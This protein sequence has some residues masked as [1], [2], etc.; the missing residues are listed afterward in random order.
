MTK[1]N[2]I[3]FDNILHKG[4][5]IFN[6]VIEKIENRNE[7]ERKE[8]LAEIKP[9]DNNN[10]K[11]YEEINEKQRKILYQL[12]KGYKT[13]LSLK[14]RA[15][16]ILDLELNNITLIANKNKISRNKVKRWKER[17][18]KNQE[19]LHKIGL[20]EPHKLKRAIISLLSDKRRSG[21][22]PLFQSE[23]IA[24]I[25]LISLQ[26]PNIMGVPIS[27]WTGLTLKNKVI[28]LEI[29][30]NISERTIT[31]YLKNLDINLHQYKGWLNSMEKNP[32]FEEYKSRIIITS[33]D[34]KTGIQAIEHIVPAKKALPGSIEKIES[35]YKRNGTTTL[36][37]TRNINTGEIMEYTLQPTRNEKDYEQHIINVIN[38]NPDAKHILI[39]DQLNT[40]MSESMVI[41]IAKKCDIPVEM[42]GVK[43]KNGI[44]KSMKSRKKFLE[45]STHKIQVLFTPKHAS[46][47]NQIEIW[48]GILSRH[49][50][51]R[52]CSFKSVEELEQKIREYIEYY[53]RCLAKKFNWSYSGKT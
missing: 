19:Q 5:E 49:L 17:W 15:T 12:S 48:F 7:N 25:I 8:E 34:E 31:R 3:M 50:L 1:D 42:L 28:E 2:T 27:H 20:E 11:I 33:T 30:K 46:W 9:E 52:R 21:K 35:E 22:P 26:D 13:E 43:G 14:V 6:W 38:R 51:N 39:M 23:Q 40:H 10:T 53:N 4:K 41:L 18:I 45:D 29:V 37:A 36:I 32:D 47:L 44:L 16:I 24:A